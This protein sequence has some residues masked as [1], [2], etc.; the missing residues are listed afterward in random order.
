[1]MYHFG[2]LEQDNLFTKL[3][4]DNVLGKISDE[5]F[6]TMSESYAGYFCVQ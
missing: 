3:N 6:K 4:K 2:A 5:R 1:M